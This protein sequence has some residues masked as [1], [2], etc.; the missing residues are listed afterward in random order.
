MG[1]CTNRKEQKQQAIIS[2]VLMRLNVVG[3]VSV[4]GIK[5]KTRVYMLWEDV[6]EEKSVENMINNCCLQFEYGTL[7]KITL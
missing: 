1:K 6:K 5:S 4:C 7:K 2:L 3:C